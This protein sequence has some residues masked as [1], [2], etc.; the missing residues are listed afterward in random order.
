MESKNLIS[1]SFVVFSR[2][3]RKS[4]AVFASLGKVINIA[5]LAVDICVTSFCKIPSVLRL[6]NY[7]AQKEGDF[8]TFDLEEEGQGLPLWILELCLLSGLIK[9]DSSYLLG[10]CSMIIIRQS[11]CT[12]FCNAWALLFSIE[13]G[14]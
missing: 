10:D 5:R 9:F 6:L 7:E 12:A 1:P 11:P 14:K 3:T 4:F 13:N 2:W 8:V